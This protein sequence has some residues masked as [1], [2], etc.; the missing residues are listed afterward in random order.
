MISLRSQIT[1]NVLSYLFLHSKQMFYVNE[2]ARQLKAD[3][4]NLTRKLNELVREGVLKSEV[5]GNLK[6]FGVN[7]RFPFREEYRRIVQQTVGLEALLREA[8]KKLHG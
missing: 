1:Q 3:S 8:L 7:P 5:R 2:L 4:G 6:Y